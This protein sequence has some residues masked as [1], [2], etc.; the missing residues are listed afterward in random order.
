MNTKIE[1]ERKI[2]MIGIGLRISRKKFMFYIGNE[3]ILDLNCVHLFFK[4]NQ[5]FKLFTHSF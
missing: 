2:F 4:T 1:S 3:T 5:P